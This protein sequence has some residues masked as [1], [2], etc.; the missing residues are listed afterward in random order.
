MKDKFSNQATAY[1]Q[2]RPTYPDEL[3]AFILQGIENKQLAWDCATGNGQA[4][5]VL[6]QYFEQVYAT[7]ISAPQLAKAVHL[8]NIQY[9]QQA[10]E[11][12]DFAPCSFDL[13]TVAQAVHWFDFDAFYAAVRRVAK[14]QATIA[15]WGYGTL[16]LANEELDKRFKHFYHQV[17]GRY[18]D[19][20]RRHIDALYETV[21]FPFEAVQTWSHTTPLTWHRATFEGYLNS[22]SGVQNFIHM[23]GYNPVD[24]LM[25]EMA[26]F[27]SEQ[28]QA[29]LYLPFFAKKGRVFKI[30]RQNLTD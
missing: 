13:I 26:P 8:P 15:I 22:W 1:A 20:E 19:A 3:Y 29:V 10:A 27:W 18:W 21:A 11:Q 30:N 16:S 9:S 17:I 25:T 14:P 24:K 2:F 12:A 6:A 23:E 7:D 5:R 28:E 4:A